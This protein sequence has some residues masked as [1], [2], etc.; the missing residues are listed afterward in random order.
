MYM[1]IHIYIYTHI[2]LT[3]C[4]SILCRQTIVHWVDNQIYWSPLFWQADEKNWIKINKSINSIIEFSIRL[5]LIEWEFYFS[6]L[7]FVYSILL[8]CMY[9]IY[10][11]IISLRGIASFRVDCSAPLAHSF[12]LL[13]LCTHLLFVSY[14]VVK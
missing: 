1:G 2:V 6:N 3:I 12:T 7:V 10:M 14:S 4:L 11:Y 5:M 8:R 9:K 13:F